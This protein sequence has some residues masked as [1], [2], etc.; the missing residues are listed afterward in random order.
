[1]SDLIEADEDVRP[2]R[3][4]QANNVQAVRNDPETGGISGILQR[5]AHPVALACL[6]FFRSAAIVVYVLC[7]L[8]KS[9]T[10]QSRG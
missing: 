5:S 1:M 7:G 8:C 6:Y 4:H 9:S 3:N 10:E 2:L